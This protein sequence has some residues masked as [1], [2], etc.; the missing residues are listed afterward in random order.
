MRHVAGIDVGST[1]TK[2]AIMNEEGE[3]VSRHMLPTGFKLTQ[4]SRIVFEQALQKAD[5]NEEDIEYVVST[6]YGRHQ[7]DFKDVSV[8]DLTSASR[9][10]HWFFPETR[11]VLDIGGQTMKACKMDE[12]A[13]VKSFR[14]NDKCAAGTGAFLEKTARYMNFET[15]EIGDLADTSTKEVEIS[16]VCAVFAESEVINQLS[17]SSKPAD[18]MHG[19]MVSLVGRSFQLMR[20]VKMEPHYTLVG[21]IMR[22]PTMVK[23]LKEKL[24]EEVVSVPSDDMSQY[25]GAIGCAVLGK[26]RLAKL[27]RGNNE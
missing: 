20:R 16:G 9:G 6:G 15:E 19:A 18:I 8:T 17:L 14:L 7:V 22:F 2:V 26:Q 13:K 25:V 23:A 21:G 3:L 5:L 4:V 1:Y 27:E 10:A 12:K 11:T 24:G